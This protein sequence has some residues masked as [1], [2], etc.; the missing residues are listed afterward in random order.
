MSPTCVFL[1]RCTIPPLALLPSGSSRETRLRKVDLT[2]RFPLLPPDI[3]RTEAQSIELVLARARTFLLVFSLLA[4]YLD[5]TDPERYSRWATELFVVYML[6]GLVILILLQWQKLEP[7]PRMQV[8]THSI[9]LTWTFAVT[10]ISAGPSSP[11]FAFFVF[12]LLAAAYRWGLRGTLITTGF[13]VGV[14]LVEAVLTITIS[15][16]Q[17]NSDFEINRF[18]IRFAYLSIVGILTG[19]L[20]EREKRLRAR[21][22]VTASLLQKAQSERTLKATIN[23]VLTELLRTFSA[24]EALL[25]I[26]ESAEGTAYLWRK[27]PNPASVDC[28]ELDRQDKANYFFSKTSE[29]WFA[30]R[31]EFKD[32]KTAAVQAASPAFL[33]RYEF[34]SI[35]AVPI[36]FQGVW[37]GWLFL[38]DA[39]F[40]DF[41]R[42]T[43]EFLSQSLKQ[44]A[45]AIYNVYLFRR[46]R[47]RI[48]VLERARLAREL[49]DTVIQS[50]I[51]AEIELEVIRRQSR[52]DQVRSDDLSRIQEIVREQVGRL[53]GLMHQLR[54]AEISPRELVS[55][56]SE[57]VERFRT[58][59]GI[60]TRLMCD[61]QDPPLQAMVARELAQ[62]TQEALVNVRRH[63]R[64]KNVLVRF[65]S[66][67]GTWK[68]IIHDDGQGFGF[69]GRLSA[70]DLEKQWQAPFV[71]RERVSRV[72][73]KLDIESA[74]GHGARL[75]ITIPKTMH[76]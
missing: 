56:L 31:E 12:V 72:G 40:D 27:P 60:S 53:R 73:G 2:P 38:F 39:P 37:N 36:S 52:T 43:L 51:A 48:G 22:L 69:S 8:I 11:F 65:G 19:Y 67:N 9:D 44:T 49:H 66:D 59:T 68:L 62:I 15:S 30:L 75:E 54:P 58:E 61:E 23:A 71:I 21:V 24:K 32:R 57:L 63:A 47:S 3:R 74:P 6:Y 41:D 13:V 4:V 16:L 28:Y 46:L 7:S 34:Q 50:L 18:I 70:A 45:P 17:S 20:S 26:E 33:Q 64:A 42:D 10:V 76:E 25:A 55:F 29:P 1:G 5:P 14:H 35:A